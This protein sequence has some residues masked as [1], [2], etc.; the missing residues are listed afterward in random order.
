MQGITWKNVK[1]V[2]QVFDIWG[3]EKVLVKV[4]N[5]VLLF[6]VKWLFIVYNFPL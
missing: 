2:K 3:Y 5:K 1:A 6:T 4:C